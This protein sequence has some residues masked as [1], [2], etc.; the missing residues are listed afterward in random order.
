MDEGR[1]EQ[2]QMK[3]FA[4]GHIA[5]LWWCCSAALQRCFRSKVVL[6]P[7][8]VLKG[9][10]LALFFPAFSFCFYQSEIFQSSEAN[11]LQTSCQINLPCLCVRGAVWRK[12][13]GRATGM[14]CQRDLSGVLM[15]PVGIG[16][17]TN[18]LF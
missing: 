2:R 15:G 6:S 5:I 10:V 11:W 3:L 9:G 18:G 8:R 17:V 13:A 14:L 7:S 12:S 16:K 4:E 1:L